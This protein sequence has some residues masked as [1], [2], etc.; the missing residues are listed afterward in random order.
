METQAIPQFFGFPRLD[1]SLT[2]PKSVI[3]SLPKYARFDWCL[4]IQVLLFSYWGTASI[5]TELQMLNCQDCS[6]TVEILACQIRG[7]DVANVCL[8]CA[9]RDY[10]DR[11][12][13]TLINAEKAGA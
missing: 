7:R 1:L 13:R 2:R 4:Y 8:E 6:A 3:K 12:T 9:N 5:G 10:Q 11:L